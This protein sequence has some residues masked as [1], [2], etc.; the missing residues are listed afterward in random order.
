M[1]ELNIKNPG[2]PFPIR[3]WNFSGR[4]LRTIGF[5]KKLEAEQLLHTAEK[6]TGLKDFGDDYFVTPL[7]KLIESI[8]EEANLHAFGRYVTEKR[9]V[10]L[11]ANRLRVE[12]YYK[13]YPETNEIKL[14]PIWWIVGLQRTGTTFLH[15][16]IANTADTASV[17]SWEVLNPVPFDNDPANKK[18]INIGKTSEK[19]LRYI[20]PEFFS[21]HPVE[22]LSPEEEVLLL[23]MSFLSTV[24]EAI[25]HVP[26]YARWVEQQDQRPAYHYMRKILQLLQLQRR[27][28]VRW[29]LKSPHH[30]EYLKEL[31]DVFPEAHLIFT[32]RDPLVTIASFCSMVFF[33]KRIF[34]STVSK[35]MI[36][37]HWMNKISLMLDKSM[38]FRMDHKFPSIDISYRYLVE[39]PLDQV[40]SIFEE[41]KDT[42]TDEIENSTRTLI[43]R[44][45]RNKYGAHKYTLSDFG[46]DERYILE[47]FSNYRRQYSKFI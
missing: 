3:A 45:K 22:H 46:L 38:A 31:T 32:H 20:A 44:N 47:A 16:L 10:N 21:I 34:S 27:D 15:R 4:L 11:L 30:L 39:N 6:Q 1:P 28:P 24:P 25:L 35:K 40:K 42:W 41:F 17:S 12:S 26:T 36:A 33:S 5:R 37:E 43:E 18:R 7:N 13:R 23:D 14:L 19:G 2:Y 8:N 29:V 9:L